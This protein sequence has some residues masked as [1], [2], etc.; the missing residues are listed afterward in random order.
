MP[1]WERDTRRIQAAQEAVLKIPGVHSVYVGPRYQSGRKTDEMALCVLVR[2]KKPLEDVAPRDRVPREVA[3]IPTDVIEADPSVA[4]GGGNKDIEYIQPPESEVP[5]FDDEEYSPILGGIACEGAGGTGTLGCIARATDAPNNGKFVLLSNHH[6]LVNKGSGEGKTVRQP[7]E[8]CCCCGTKVG[9]VLRSRN[10]MSGAYYLDHPA[11]P[12]VDA[13]I[14]LML[15]GVQ[16]LAEIQNG[17]GSS[18]GTNLVRAVRADAQITNTLAI[19]KRGSRTGTTHGTIESRTFAHAP[20][21]NS[22]KALA[23]RN[24]LL[25]DPG[26]PPGSTSGIFRFDAGGDSGSVVTTQIGDEVVGLL[27][28]GIVFRPLAPGNRDVIVVKGLANNIHQVISELHIDIVTASAAGQILTNPATVSPLAPGGVPQPIQ[29][30]MLDDARVRIEQTLPG[31]TYADLVRRHQSEV[32]RLVRTNRRVGAIWKRN[33]GQA[34]VQA[35]LDSIERP[36]DP[37]PESIES[38][39]IAESAARIAVVLKRY[40]SAALARDIAAYEQAVAELRGSTFNQFL[41][42][43]QA[44]EPVRG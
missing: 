4:I 24:Q 13:A 33:G 3:G 9:T 11:T 38:R 17:V 37:I 16:A 35:M 27:W 23:Y 41:S 15:P 22:R 14:A 12:N 29:R 28:A 6:V 20:E 10:T 26:F 39:P 8:S 31:R 42:Q 44:N 21:D 30:T 34:L 19:Q 1:D 40:G 32:W 36:D 7:R 43:L 18:G 5:F 2:T 25:L